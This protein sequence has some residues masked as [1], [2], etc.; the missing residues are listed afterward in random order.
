MLRDNGK[1][2]LA[3]VLRKN[4]ERI[5]NLKLTHSH[6]YSR[7]L[8]VEER[9]WKYEIKEELNERSEWITERVV[10]WNETKDTKDE[11]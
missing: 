8:V 7:E 9:K 5:W 4:E 6:T 1:S 2:R 3:R 11:I 10:K